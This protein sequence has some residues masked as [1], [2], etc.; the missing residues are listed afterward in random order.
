M[1]ESSKPLPLTSAME[2]LCRFTAPEEREALRTESSAALPRRLTVFVLWC[3]G[4]LNL[5]VLLETMKIS[6]ISN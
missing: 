5:E 6:V 4:S 1:T 3:G 2:P